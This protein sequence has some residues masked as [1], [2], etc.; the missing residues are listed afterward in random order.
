MKSGGTRVTRAALTRWGGFWGSEGSGSGARCGHALLCWRITSDLF[1][2]LTSAA[3][4]LA[5]SNQIRAVCPY[6][7][8]RPAPYPPTLL[9]CSQA[10][11]RVPFWGPLKHAARMR[12]AAAEHAAGGGGRGPILLLPDA[13]DGHFIHERDLLQTKAE[14]YAFLAAALEGRLAGAP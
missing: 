1:I 9:T 10:D 11:L 5:C 6:Q 3:P 13:Q 4:H 7:G 14:Q 8:V 2:K 12:A